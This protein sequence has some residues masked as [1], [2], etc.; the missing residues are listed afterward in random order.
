MGMPPRLYWVWLVLCPIA[1]WSV[2]HGMR[3]TIEPLLARLKG[4]HR[5]LVDRE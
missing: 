3:K 4:L 2:H 1:A 5:E